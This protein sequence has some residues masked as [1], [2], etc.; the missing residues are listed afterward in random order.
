M[1]SDPT[2]FDLGSAL[3]N[4]TVTRP[5]TAQEPPGKAADGQNRYVHLLPC[6]EVRI[7]DRLIPMA[8]KCLNVISDIAGIMFSIVSHNQI[9][10][11]LQLKPGKHT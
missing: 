5:Q 9:R 6:N 7:I 1:K 4:M 3:V 10:P 2:P 8:P 11:C